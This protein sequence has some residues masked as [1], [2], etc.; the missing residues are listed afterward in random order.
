MESRLR[1]VAISTAIVGLLAVVAVVVIGC[2]GMSPFLSAQFA[3]TMLG[4]DDG[5][6]AQGGGAAPVPE[7]P[8]VDQAIQSILDLPEQERGLTVAVSNASLLRVRFAITF[9]VSAGPGGFVPDAELQTYTRAGYTDALVP[10][11]GNTITIGCDTLSLLSGTKLLTLEFVS[12]E[13]GVPTLPAGTVSGENVEPFIFQLT[14][15][16]N[17][18][19]VI[20]LPEIIVFGSDDPNFV[21]VGGASV[22]DL[23]T[24]RGFVYYS[25]DVELPTGKPVEA[26]RIQG[27]LCNIGFGTAPEW[28]LDKTISDE[29]VQSFQYVAGG[30]IVV[31]VLDRS[32][33]ST[34]VFRN[35]ATWLVTD[36]AGITIH[37][38]EP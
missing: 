15:R 10:G 30:A 33:D 22:G 25:T 2:D 4:T 12:T 29:L 36:A 34:T 20:P 35:Q 8:T 27:T 26:Q 3:N 7:D 32:D 23:C 5:G 9:A 17:A 14:R 6:L 24:Q 21:C 18:A 37:F 28:R 13:S 1:R 31:T 19:A 11:S 16:D 38:P